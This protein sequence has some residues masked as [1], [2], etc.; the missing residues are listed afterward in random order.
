MI[1]NF[2][3]GL[4]SYLPLVGVLVVAVDLNRER[5][6][7]AGGR[8]GP[9]SDFHKIHG[10][11][12]VPAQPGSFSPEKGF[13]ADPDHDVGHH[14]GDSA[15]FGLGSFLLLGLGGRSGGFPGEQGIDLAQGFRGIGQAQIE[16]FRTPRPLMRVRPRP[17]P[18]R[19]PQ[20]ILRSADSSSGDSSFGLCLFFGFAFRIRILGF[21][22]IVPVFLDSLYRSLHPHP[23]PPANPPPLRARRLPPLRPPRL[24]LLLNFL[25]FF[26]ILF[27]RVVRIIRGFHFPG[28]SSSSSAIS[29]SSSS[30]G[31]GFGS[32]CNHLRWLSGGSEVVGEREIRWGVRKPRIAKCRVVC[33]GT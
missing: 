31:F 28:S 13:V 33:R 21:L 4:T 19:P 29:S 8:P 30:F 6:V 5:G 2:S 16:F 12:L 23:I 26:R 10:H 32:A 24:N 9:F 20:Q 22:Q 7:L 3:P 11:A 15:R 27:L 17:P 18:N 14:R 1:S 25:G